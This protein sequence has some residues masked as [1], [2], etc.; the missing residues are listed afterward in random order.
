MPL[1][2]LRKT[3]ISGSNWWL[4]WFQISGGM[5]VAVSVFILW[6]SAWYYDHVTSGFLFKVLKGSPQWVP[7]SSPLFYW[8][9]GFNRMA[10]RFSQSSDKKQSKTEENFKFIVDRDGV[11]VWRFVSKSCFS[12]VIKLNRTVIQN[13]EDLSVGP[14]DLA[15]ICKLAIYMYSTSRHLPVLPWLTCIELCPTSKIG[16]FGSSSSTFGSSSSK[17]HFGMF[18]PHYSILFLVG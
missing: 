15:W 18:L 11:L 3:Y 6:H 10:S 5:R 17:F 9:E 16:G 8:R 4:D 7:I 12:L 13:L 14:V 2:H 1:W